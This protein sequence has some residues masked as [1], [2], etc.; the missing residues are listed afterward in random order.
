MAA[1]P[2]QIVS[3]LD[4]ADSLAVIEH[5][6]RDHD[7]R[8]SVY[9]WALQSSRIPASLDQVVFECEGPG[10]IRDYLESRGP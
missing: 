1:D 10:L 4:D 7:L 6:R 3:L 5:L 8:R 9:L 2:E